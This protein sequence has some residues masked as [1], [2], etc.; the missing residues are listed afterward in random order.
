MIYEIVPHSFLQSR[1]R[2]IMW[3]LDRH[4]HS[5]L[6]TGGWLLIHLLLSSV[7]FI[8]YFFYYTSCIQKGLCHPKGRRLKMAL[9]IRRRNVYSLQFSPW[10]SYYPMTYLLSLLILNLVSF[11]QG[12]MMLPFLIKDMLMPHRNIPPHFRGTSCCLVMQVLKY[13]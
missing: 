13:I 9:G 5:C 12:A 4:V 1:M 10:K 3:S 6:M 8:T 11:I 2:I 7:F